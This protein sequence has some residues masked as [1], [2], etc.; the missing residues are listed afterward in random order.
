MLIIYVFFKVHIGDCV[1]Y[2][3]QCIKE[4]TTFDYV[5]N[6][7]TAIPVTKEPRG[8]YYISGDNM[9]TSLLYIVNLFLKIPK[10]IHSLH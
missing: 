9:D 5:I 4:G 3:E 6:D 1:K 7:L 10:F 8:I 2:L